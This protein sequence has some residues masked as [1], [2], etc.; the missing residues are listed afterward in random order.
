MTNGTVV[1]GAEVLRAFARRVLAASGADDDAARLCAEVFVDANLAGTDTH[2]IARLGQY[3]DAL[4][5]GRVCGHARP[6]VVAD[7]GAVS[8][9]DAHNALGPVG[10]RFATDVA[11]RAA[12]RYGMAAVAVR[13]SNHAGSMSWY[14][15]RAARAGMF[16]MILTGST[17]AMVAPF[18]GAG[19]FL[20]TNAFGY[21]VPAG[22]E[23]LTFD[24]ALS[25][26]SRSRLEAFQRAGASLPEGWA[27]GPDGLPAHDAGEVIAGID[28]LAGHS[29]LPFGGAEGAHKGFGFSLFT[30]LLCG[31]VAGARWG[32]TK[33]GPDPAG[34]GHFVQ[35][36]DLGALGVPRDEV[37]K[38]VAA[39]C[40]DLRA[41]PAAAEQEPVRLP[42]DRRRVCVEQRTRDGIPVPP[43]V[44][45]EL[46]EVAVLT[47]VEP[48]DRARPGC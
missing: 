2:G 42:G 14:I 27:V 18:H 21:G 29:L 8:T 5:R 22:G 28:S 13:G 39:L 20:G 6:E 31:P 37:E 48:L 7:S 35:C 17:K 32:P 38:R 19:P 40:T 26:A 33:P 16:A 15:E 46:D 24:A 23:T 9:V 4:A 36:L 11:V 41:V 47:E 1:F 45:R 44:L 43:N 10:L 3:A 34:V 25:V 30:E 12:G